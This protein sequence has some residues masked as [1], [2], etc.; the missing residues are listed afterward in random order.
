MHQQ[1]P[2]TRKKWYPWDHGLLRAVNSLQH[3][4]RQIWRHN[5]VI[6]PNEYLIFTFSES[7]NPWVYSLQFLFKSTINSW[8]YERKCEWVFFF[9]TQCM[10][11]MSPL[12]N[13]H[14][15][16]AVN[17]NCSQFNKLQLTKETKEGQIFSLLVW[18]FPN[19][20]Y[21][22]HN[23]VS[24]L[25]IFHFLPNIWLTTCAQTEVLHDNRSINYSNSGDNSS[26]YW[27]SRSCITLPFSI[28]APYTWWSTMQSFSP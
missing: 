17:N 26:A 3:L 21:V 20:Y 14:K 28:A 22:L 4:A 5:Y 11:S 15:Q 6:D 7:I 12:S 2:C 13:Q 27:L 18:R 16:S 10:S 24:W 9:W 19:C 8:R 25:L 23:S 1:V